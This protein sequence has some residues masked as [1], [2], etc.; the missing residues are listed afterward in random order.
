MGL[1][2]R[3]LCRWMLLCHGL[4]VREVVL[5]WCAGV[6]ERIEISVVS[7]DRKSVKNRRRAIH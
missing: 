4:L 7:A 3:T 5:S 6:A 1:H 2:L